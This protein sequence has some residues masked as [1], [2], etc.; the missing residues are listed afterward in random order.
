MALSGST[1][2]STTRDDIITE[3][4]Q[5]CGVVGEN[6]TPSS[7][8]L[9]DCNRTLNMMIEAWQSDGLQLWV[10]DEIVCF[11]IKDKQTYKLGTNGN[12]ACLSDELITSTLSAAASSSDTSISVT[13]TSG[14]SSS[15]VI[16]VVVDSEDIHW[17]TI[18]SVDSSTA[19]TLTDALDDDA[20][21]GNKIF[22]YTTAYTERP[23]RINDAFVRLSDNQ[24][25]PVRIISR[26]EYYNLTP[27]TTSSYALELYFDP[28]LTNAEY[29]V[30]PVAGQDNLSNELHLI[31]HR[32][33][34]YFTS[35]SDNPHFPSEWYLV[36]SWGLAYY[37]T[38]KYD[39]PAGKHD[40]IEKT[41]ML[42]KE[43][44]LGWDTENMTSMYL[45]PSM[46]DY[47]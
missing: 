3:A 14:M 44:L 35:G 15:D 29:K 11:F 31:V 40:R 20:A 19:L 5:I 7:G 41:F 12:R 43:K 8:K 24:D 1:N 38:T 25:Q 6:E 18:S 45:A 37:L 17:T 39:V 32:P 34:Q 10:Q 9:S 33:F 28:Q 47:Y 27:K 30:W 26:E 13:S 4:L 36:L 21:S 42:L 23:L 2:Y 46:E 22:T 16:G